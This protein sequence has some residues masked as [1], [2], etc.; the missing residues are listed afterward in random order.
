MI[1]TTNEELDKLARERIKIS[2]KV[3]KLTAILEDDG[4]KS[5]KIQPNPVVMMKVDDDN[6]GPVRV[7]P[8]LSND[9]TEPSLTISKP[10]S[11]TTAESISDHFEPSAATPLSTAKVSISTDALSSSSSQ[12][13]FE[14]SQDVD[15]ALIENFGLSEFKPNQLEAINITLNGEDVFVLMPAGGGK[16]LCYQLP[17]II[18]LYKRKGITFVVSP[19][20]H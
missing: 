20:F 18:Q 14:W 19:L 13:H 7:L 17:A 5:N 16:S 6:D 3:K 1:G 11:A 12:P 10:T 15:K 4:T 8:S 9:N 2:N